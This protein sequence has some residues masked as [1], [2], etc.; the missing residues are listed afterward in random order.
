M[1][2]VQKLC[3]KS[4][5]HGQDNSLLPEIEHKNM[6]E[7]VWHLVE[8]RNSREIEKTREKNR[9]ASPARDWPAGYTLCGV[10]VAIIKNAQGMPFRE[11]SPLPKNCL[12]NGNYLQ[13]QTYWKWSRKF[14]LLLLLLLHACFYLPKER[15]WITL[16]RLCVRPKPTY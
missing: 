16:L 7:K 11:F 4:E 8:S 10:H 14:N 12:Q 5:S 6:H 1:L 2:S 15:S 13:C 3:L 9:G